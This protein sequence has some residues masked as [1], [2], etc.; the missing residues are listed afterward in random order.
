MR[1][2]AM[3]MFGLGLLLAVEGCRHTAG[4]CDCEQPPPPCAGHASA[5]PAE[6]PGGPVGA[7]VA[8]PEVIKEPPKPIDK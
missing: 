3:V 6:A 8:A 7:P 1:R 2:L 4:V 5:V